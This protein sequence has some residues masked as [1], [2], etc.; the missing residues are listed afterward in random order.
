MSSTTDADLLD[1]RKVIEVS[2]R[3][4]ERPTAYVQPYGNAS[5]FGALRQSDDY[6]HG[7]ITVRGDGDA[8]A[9]TMLSVNIRRINR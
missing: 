9:K 4:T 1:H 8:N 6:T 2:R 7:N 5:F 3:E